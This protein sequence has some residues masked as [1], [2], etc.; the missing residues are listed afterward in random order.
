[1]DGLGHF[2]AGSMCVPRAGR[3][4]DRQ[5][6]ANGGGW[7]L[8]RKMKNLPL[9]LTGALGPLIDVVTTKPWYTL[10]AKGQARSRFPWQGDH[11]RAVATVTEGA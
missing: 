11:L 5:A 6:S 8:Y 2:V 3:C 9:R 4:C 1:M 10:S 7:P